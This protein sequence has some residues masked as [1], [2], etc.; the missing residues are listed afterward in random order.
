M[1]SNFIHDINRNN[2]STHSLAWENCSSD[3]WTQTTQD[4]LFGDCFAHWYRA[5]LEPGRETYISVWMSLNRN[6]LIS[7][8]S[9]FLIIFSSSSVHVIPHRLR[10]GI[11]VPSL[12]IIELMGEGEKV[13]G[14]SLKRQSNQAK[15]LLRET[16]NEYI[17][18]YNYALIFA[19]LSYPFIFKRKV[20]N[21]LSTFSHFENTKSS[22]A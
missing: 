6:P 12:M 14:F 22:I 7:V 9:L 15:T 3:E 18:N 8:F 11:R 17:I 21:L 19:H 10:R 13:S 20:N 4:C 1:T 2:K 5:L 16:W